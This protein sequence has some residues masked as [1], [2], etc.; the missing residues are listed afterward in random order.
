LK[1]SILKIQLHQQCST[2]IEQRITDLK[3]ILQEAQDAANNETKSSAGDKHETGRAMAQLET[4][5]LTGQLAEVLKTQ[6]TIQKINPNSIH[7]SITL[8]SLVNTNNGTFYI[9]IGLG[10]VTINNTS[11]FV[12]S[13]VSPIGQLLMGLKANDTFSFNGK[14]YVIG[15]IC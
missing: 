14:N 2:I 12:I 15:E 8:G 3:S 5:K 7:N 6:E 11:Y 1:N 4:E 13:S 10:K 9:A